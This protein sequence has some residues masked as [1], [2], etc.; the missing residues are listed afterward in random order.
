MTI[1]D[2]SYFLQVC[3]AGSINA[4]ARS[5]YIS[6]QG[7]SRI[8]KNLEDELGYPIFDRTKT[9]VIPTEDGR[10]LEKYAREILAQADAMTLELRRLHEAQQGR[11]RVAAGYGLI[12]Y[13]GP[14]HVLRFRRENP[15][16]A[17]ELSEYTDQRAAEAVWYREADW[18]LI[19]LPMDETRYAVEPLA[20]IPLYLLVH[21][22][23]PLSQQRT[24]EIAQLRG[25]PIA[26]QNKEFNL[27]QLILRK[28]LQA[29]FTPDIVF[30]SNGICMCNQLCLQN[31]TVSVV[32]AHTMRNLR[33]DETR[34]IPFADQEMRL[35]CALIR[36]LDAPVSP[37]MV[38]LK[39]FLS[40]LAEKKCINS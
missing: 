38:R 28:C 19:N 5:L 6:A 30:E 15:D 9:G 14:D 39:T 1:K 13:F 7:L 29:G 34:L 2:L 20:S 35:Q 4:A 40:E 37:E 22:D 18:G 8:L 16:I 25:Q 26:I 11:V 24:M 23:N 27:H 12:G 33:T 3:Q 21:L 36:R 17:L 10:I 31:E 32:P